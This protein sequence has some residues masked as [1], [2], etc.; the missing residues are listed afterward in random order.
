[1]GRY[2]RK[3][4][5]DFETTVYDGQESTEVW[6]AAFVEIFTNHNPVICHSI[7]EMYD[8]FRYLKDKKVIIYFHNLKFDGSF[9]IDFLM[10]KLKY[11]PAWYTDEEDNLHWLRE[12]DMPSESY[13]YSISDKGQ[14]YTITICTQAGRIIEFRDS[15]KLL[16]FSLEEIGKAFQTK[17]RKLTME[18]EGERYAGCPISPEE[19]EYIKNDVLVLKEALEICFQ[20]GHDKLTIGSCCLSEFKQLYDK[21]DY[22]ILFPDLYGVEIEASKFSATNAGAY[23]RRGYRG[24]WTYLVKGKENKIFE[25][26]LT[27]DVNSLYPSV[28]HSASGNYYPTGHPHFWEG[29]YIPDIALQKNKYYY[30]TVQTSF[31]LKDGYLPTIQ[32]KNDWRYSPRKFLE[33]SALYYNGKYYEFVKTKDGTEPVTVTMT[34]TQ[35]DWEL[36]QKHYKLYNTKI[37]HGCWFF[38]E[39]GLFDGYINHYMGIKV[40]SKGAKRTL[41]KLFLNNLYGKFSASP[42]SSFKV[43]Y[44]DGEDIKQR[45]VHE[46]EKT[47]GYIAIGAAIT[48]YARYFTITHAQE[49]YHGKDKPGF[50]YADTDSIHCDLSPDQLIDI[51]THETKM[52]CW[53]LE[54]YWDKAI[55][56]RPKTYIEHV[57]HVDGEPVKPYYNI[58]CAGMPKRCKQL[59]AISLEGS[60]AV[61]RNT[62]DYWDTAFLFDKSGVPIKRDLTDFKIGLQVPGKLIPKRIKG[63]LVLKNG[64]FTMHSESP[65]KIREGK[66]L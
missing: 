30:I 10:R 29:N 47:P 35:T 34:L 25:N 45:T 58:T 1:M 20:E 65:H 4:A 38:A 44:M 48:S 3:F 7:D 63:G 19:K 39:K 49:N 59:F 23:I 15:L 41:A 66:Y 21:E 2:I 6:S 5:A 60:A 28:M 62:P 43:M 11:K 8:R 56:V 42:D 24:A 50:I 14:W 13:R 17:H 40:N 27:A 31:A 22:K 18:Y 46:E 61:K 9:W 32:I 37:L 33:T 54:S 26:G 53:K 52:L 51:K 16:P 57:T 64:V 36:I 12:K 55:F